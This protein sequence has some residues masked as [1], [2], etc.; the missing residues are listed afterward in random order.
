MPYLRAFA[1]ILAM[2]FIVILVAPLQAL[3]RRVDSPVQH[4]IQKFFCKTMN[5]IIGIEVIAR[6]VLHAAPPRFIVANHVSW[7]DILA[8]T[9]LYPL[10][11]LA[12]V[13]VASWPVLG[14]LARLQGTVFVDRAQRRA[15]P[16]VNAAL[17]RILREGRDLVVFAEGTSS[18]GAKVMKFNAS[19][20]AMLH[21][22]AQ[23]G[24][25][26]AVTLVPVAFAYAP[27]NGDAGDFDAG[28]Y[29]DMSFVPH[30]WALMRRGGARCHVS[31]G[32]P[33][34]P[35]SFPDRKALAEA[36]QNSVQG[37]LGDGI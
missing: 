14:F 10:T 15:I 5:R 32:A 12:K 22:F 18:D 9:S 29:G 26:P 20:F 1:I 8:I 16:L 35:A 4:W 28:W 13:E 30:L 17:A 33:L 24:D 31:F 11:F 25:R 7:T 6:G 3:A 21:D 23:S 36:A 27:R 34:Q 19:H 2:A 37:L